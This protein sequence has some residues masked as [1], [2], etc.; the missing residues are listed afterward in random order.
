MSSYTQ[1]SRKL[2]TIA[3]RVVGYC[4]LPVD[5][6]Q[7][8][9]LAD[10]VAD[11]GVTSR[12][13]PDTASGAIIRVEMTTTGNELR[14]ASNGSIPDITDKLGEAIYEDGQMIY[15]GLSEA[16]KGSRSE[17]TNFKTAINTGKTAK[18][19]V[20]YVAFV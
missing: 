12:P 14:V 11:D 19:H 17:I 13:I 18:L 16:Y 20:T 9:E 4:Y 7:V 5:D 6:T 15:I 2:N 8:W 1:H 10:G 3:D